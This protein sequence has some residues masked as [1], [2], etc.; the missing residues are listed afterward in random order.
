M[1]GLL[2]TTTGTVA[3]VEVT[4]T[5]EGIRG[6]IGC[7]WIE[8]FGPPDGSWT[9]YCDEEGKITAKEINFKATYLA[10]TLGWPRGDILVGDVLLLGPPDNEGNDTA[11]PDWLLEQIK[12]P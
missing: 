7:E 12:T 8:V 9:G 6:A 10:V 2:I 1:K 4:D 3:V 11:V 5:L